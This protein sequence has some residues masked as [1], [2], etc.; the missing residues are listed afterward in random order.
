M[1]QVP[2]TGDSVKLSASYVLALASDQLWPAGPGREQKKGPSR[3]QASAAFKKH[4][5]GP[6]A[7]GSWVQGGYLARGENRRGLTQKRRGGAGCEAQ[8]ASSWATTRRP[9]RDSC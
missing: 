8:W 9:G 1:A 6:R 2:V 7:F 5:L 4:G 3:A